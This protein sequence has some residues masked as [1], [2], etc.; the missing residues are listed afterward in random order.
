MKD[1]TIRFYD[2]HAGAFAANTMNADMSEC[3]AGFLKYVQPGAI[4]LDAGCG[5]GRDAAA[6]LKAGYKVEAFDASGEL[7]RIAS[8]NT[9]I[10][11][12]QMRFEELDG[13]EL[14]DGIWACASLLH[15]MRTDLP[16]VMKRLYRLLKADGI[17]Y[18]SFKMGSGERIKEGRYFHDLSEEACRGI[19]E[20]AGFTV[21]E[22][23]IT[24]DVRKDR[25]A[26]R[27]VNAIARKI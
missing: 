4:I 20:E 1:R 6:F 27:W 19:L 26:E 17:L 2:E 13:C 25:E 21:L 10:E 23:F 8:A 22:S 12:R 15:V 14:Y 18:V 16:D 24:A 7:C 9:G 3:R 5:S 11:V